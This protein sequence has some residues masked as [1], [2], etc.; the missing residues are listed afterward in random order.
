MTRGTRVVTPCAGL[1]ASFTDVNSAVVT[2]V[3]EIESSGSG[4][5]VV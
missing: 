2:S 1:N 4:I 5:R 3:F